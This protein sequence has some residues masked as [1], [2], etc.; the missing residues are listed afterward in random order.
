MIVIIDNYDSFVH[1]LARYVREAGH[2]A[3]VLRND[4]ASAAEIIALAPEGVIISPGPGT[5]TDT[6]V[7]MSL[8]DIL[9]HATPML[10]VCLGHLCLAE[11]FGGVTVRATQPLHGEASDIFHDG[12]GVFSGIESPISAGRYHSLV[13]QLPDNSEALVA[14]AWSPEGEIMGIRHRNRPWHGVQF[15]PESLLTTD[16]RRMIA[17]FLEGCAQ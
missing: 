5:P 14:C 4:T 8:L 3:L 12:K 10:G 7:S 1:N 15:H 6:G 2:D 13:C 9:P 11:H 16:G 17:N